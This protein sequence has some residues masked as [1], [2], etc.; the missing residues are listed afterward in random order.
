[1][2]SFATG[3]YGEQAAHSMAMEWSR[4]LQFFYDRC[5]QADDQ[6]FIYADEDL[7]DYQEPPE[8]LEFTSTLPEEHPAWKR[9]VEIRELFPQ[10]P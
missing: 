6:G 7:E 8:W 10:N 3:L 9:I 5:K 1:M 4:R 2:V